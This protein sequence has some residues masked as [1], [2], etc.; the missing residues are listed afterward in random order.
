MDHDKLVEAIREKFGTQ[1]AAAREARLDKAVLNRAV[2][3][4]RGL[5]PDAAEQLGEALGVDPTAMFIGTQVAAKVAQ[6]EGGGLGAADALASLSRVA[7]K[8]QEMHEDGDLAV[9]PELTEAVDLLG[10]A[11][12]TFSKET[13]GSVHKLASDDY[14]EDYD[15]PGMDGRD[16]NGVRVR[17]NTTRMTTSITTMPSMTRL[18]TMAGTPTVLASPH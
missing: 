12:A 4:R 7:V 8:V 13:G 1:G 14:E 9:S 18:D 16:L 15:E 11:L 3:N 10:R 6:V 17:P 5:S 2:K